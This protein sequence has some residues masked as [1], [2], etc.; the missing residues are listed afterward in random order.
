MKNYE[1][2]KDAIIDFLNNASCRD[3][4][5]NCDACILSMIEKQL[6][7]YTR[8]ELEQWLL[9]EYVEPIKLSHDE[10]V[11]LKN[12]DSEWKWLTRDAYGGLYICDKKPFKDGKDWDSYGEEVWL[13]IYKHL[14]QFVKWEDEEPYEIAK[15]IADYEREH[16]DENC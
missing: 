12:V 1:K 3:C 16:E 2:Y 7:V 15:L 11:I 5:R 9:E 10:Y 8:Y 14:F 13:G 4:A 6:G